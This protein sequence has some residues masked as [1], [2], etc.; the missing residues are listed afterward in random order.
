MDLKVLQDVSRELER[1]Q[2]VYP[3]MHSCHEGYAVL[4]EEVHELWDEIRASKGL[5][6]N[7]RIR[8]EAVQVAAMALRFIGDLCADCTPIPVEKWQ[9]ARAPYCDA[10]GFVTSVKPSGKIIRHSET[11][12]QYFPG[13]GDK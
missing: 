11:T 13:L 3:P 6:G 8:S 7:L 2:T 4:L 12:E 9:G 1:A 10:P 5:A